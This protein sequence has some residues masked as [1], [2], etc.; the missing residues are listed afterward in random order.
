MR[1]DELDEGQLISRFAAVLPTGER[2]LLGPGD[3]CAVVAVP[4]GSVLVTTDVM[5]AGRD[6]RLD[7]S[8][9]DEIGA[10]SAAENL[11]DIAAMGA[12]TSSMVVSLVLPEDTDVDW[13]VALVAGFGDRACR[14][15]AGVVGGDLSAGDRFMISVT[16]L[17][18]STVAPVLRSGAHAGD[19]LAVAGTLG[20]SGAGLELLSRGMV[21]PSIHDDV[22]LGDLREPVRIFRA[23]EPPLEAGPEAA[24][25]G[26]SAMLDVSDGL[27][28]DAGRIAS[29]SGVVLELDSELLASDVRAL[30]TPAQLCGHPALDWVLF[31]GE[32]HPML[33]AFPSSATLPPSFRPIGVVGAVEP[34]GRPRVRLD[35]VEIS[36]GWDHFRHA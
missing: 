19:V 6:F 28:M 5:V 8:A 13:L 7:W 16:A 10:R 20:R 29:A 11:A 24:K 18:W 2:T 12:R 14:A 31:G 21:D 36:G 23:A 25:R 32:D 1:V 30:D 26:A 15:G 33:A 35:G 22:L 3:D 9:P 4:E 34:E 17:G 27:I